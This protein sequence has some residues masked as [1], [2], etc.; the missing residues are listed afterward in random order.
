MSENVE[1]KPEVSECDTASE[2]SFAPSTSSHK[3]SGIRPP[4]VRIGRLCTKHSTPKASHPPPSESKNQGIVLTTDTDSFIIGQR[5][6]VGGVRPGHIAY[7]GETHFAPGDWAGVVLDEPSGKNDG[8]VSGKRYFQCEPKRG[9]FSRLT[10]L[11]REPLLTADSTDDLYRSPSR[12]PA[13][14]VRT[15]SPPSSVRNS[16]TPS[17]SGGKGGMQVGDRVIVSSGF[18]SRPGVLKYIGET[19]FAPGNWCGVQLDDPTGKNDGSVDGIRYFDCVDKYGIFVPLAKVTLSPSAKKTFARI[20]R[21]NSKESL[22]SIGTLGSMASTNTSR[23]RMGAN[24]QRLSSSTKPITTP[25]NT[26]SLQDVLREKQNHIEQLLAEKD[27]DR[28]DAEIQSMMY[29]K[30]INELKQKIGDLEG[31]LKEEQ[32]KNEDLQFTVDEA[33]FCG[34][35]LSVKKIKVLEAQSQEYKERISKLEEE[36]AHSKTSSIGT[37]PDGESVHLKE[38]TEKVEELK[39]L[40]AA[41][42]EE[43]KNVREEERE[44]SNKILEL[45]KQLI[46]AESNMDIKVSSLSVSENCLREEIKMLSAQ[47][48]EIREEADGYKASL[49]SI[50]A[51]QKGLVEENISLKK[52]IAEGDKKSAEMQVIIA[53]LEKDSQEMVRL[54][55]ILSQ[56]EI[57]GQKHV[58]EVQGFQEKIRENVLKVDELSKALEERK[59]SEEALNSQIRE[60]V[61]RIETLEKEVAEVMASKAAMESERVTKGEE[62]KKL[63]QFVEV[64]KAQLQEASSATNSSREEVDSVRKCLTD[65]ENSSAEL[66]KECDALKKCLSENEAKLQET[67]KNL[68]AETAQ[69]CLKIEECQRLQESISEAEEKHV[70]EVEAIKDEVKK[71]TECLKIADDERES[72][73]RA[74]QE[75]EEAKKSLEENIENQKRQIESLN[76]N[77]SEVEQQKSSLQDQF[78]QLD[79]NHGDLVR[80]FQVL[81]E[82]CSQL[83]SD[84]QSLQT[85]LTSVRNSSLDT[86]SEVTRL[87]QELENEKASL[88][89]LSE[90]STATKLSL[91]KKIQELSQLVD[92]LQGEIDSL[93]AQKINRE[94]ELNAELA[95][96]KEF[97]Q[98]EMESTKKKYQEEKDKMIQ[99]INLKLEEAERN[100]SNLTA[101]ITRLEESVGSLQKDL[102]NSRNH[103]K[104]TEKELETAREQLDTLERSLKKD[105]ET[106]RARIADLEMVRN[107]SQS[108]HEDLLNRL[109]EKEALLAEIRDERDTMKVEVGA[110]RENFERQIKEIVELKANVEEVT[111]IRESESKRAEDLGEKLRDME[112]EQVDLVD[113]NEQ[114]MVTISELEALRQ[115]LEGSLAEMSSTADAKTKSFTTEQEELKKEVTR[116]TEERDAALRE[117]AEKTEQLSQTVNHSEDLKNQLKA[118]SEELTAKESALAELQSSQKGL[119]ETIREKDAKVAKVLE[120]S[121]SFQNSL[122]ENLTKK[123]DACQEL[124]KKCTS[125]E[126]TIEDLKKSLE[127]SAQEKS[128]SAEV[129]RNLEQTLTN[130]KKSSDEVDSSRAVQDKNM[131][132]LSQKLAEVTQKVSQRDEKI[133]LL[134]RQEGILKEK[135]TTLQKHLDSLQSQVEDRELQLKVTRSQL[136]AAKSNPVA[137]A[138]EIVDDSDAGAQIN[139][140]NSI[141]ADMQRKNTELVARV[142][143]L[144]AGPADS[145][146]NGLNLEMPIR[147]KPAPR[148]YCDI[149]DIFDA[150]DTEDCPV[151]ASDSPVPDVA[152]RKPGEQRV[153]PPPRKY[154]ESCE[155]F[156]HEMGECDNDESF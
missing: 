123:V 94:N 34:D 36:L 74:L 1:E 134:E 125:L 124:E 75:I 26:F 103:Q 148:L 112:D 100:R 43:I 60:K 142:Q 153:V 91:E 141:I 47:N 31:R 145:G 119:Q 66:R 12:T 135:I 30:D 85:E 56:N 61:Q 27:L 25:K 15:I 102:E 144:E 38:L 117:A 93:A 41:R 8:C 129:I 5:V 118:K 35:E 13:S 4:S 2:A 73:R 156:G 110:L 109:S 64:L 29:Q 143:I 3:P 136:E 42:E 37:E 127:T 80:K 53:N 72:L 22:T 86:N 137:P 107:S 108:S 16:V 49:A 114:M 99:E 21:S 71:L 39:K 105:L 128:H 28:Q 52:A 54:K 111:K 151:Q 20:P 48:D 57:S 50:E 115:S 122:K 55:E 67:V 155:V 98:N 96:T 97:H 82:K 79:L 32:R 45:Q 120:E 139:F 76:V 83:T 130:L 51:A 154:C 77:L 106:S 146:Y 69:K 10:R 95:R 23:L 19:Q 78:N 104:V 92:K 84:K 140:L 132:E 65:Q 88:E 121:E 7:I 89:N 24:A 126:A 113:R 147:R 101:C 149:C 6:W 63:E 87:V 131:A 18:G 116:M 81:E 138:A 58:Q 40:L 152:I 33:Q 133:N 90:S 68:E 59:V 44:R 9:I 14:P 62:I 11:T 17:R 150:H 70:R 46:E